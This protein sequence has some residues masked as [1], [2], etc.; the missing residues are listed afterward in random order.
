MIYEPGALGLEASPEELLREVDNP[1]EIINLLVVV[2]EKALITI[3]DEP[4]YTKG[5]ARPYIVRGL[6]PGKKYSFE[7]KALVKSPNG[8]EYGAKEKVELTAGDSKQ[9]VLHVRRQKRTP[10][11]AP[12]A[13][14]APV[15][16]AATK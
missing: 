16:P 2:D 10:P 11:P 15:I 14:V 4:T 3:N 8:A 5:N 1:A 12:V 13:P 6:K 7:I 9:V